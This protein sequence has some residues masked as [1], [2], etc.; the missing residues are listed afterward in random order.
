[1]QGRRHAK[2]NV[3]MFFGKTAKAIY[4]PLGGKVRRGTNGKSTGTLTLKQAFRADGNTVEGVAS[5]R[6]VVASGLGNGQA[7][8]FAIEEL[9]S[10]LRLQGFDLM[11]HRALGDKKLLRRSREALV[12]G[13]GLEG[14]E[15]VQWWQAA[16]HLP[17]FMRKTQAR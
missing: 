16:Q 9:D 11:T 7:L 15:G 17:T 1:M 4:Q 6:E 14:L 12:A 2:I 5:D 3:G 10:K 13:R 8:A